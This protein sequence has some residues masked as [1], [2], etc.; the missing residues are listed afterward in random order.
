MICTFKH[1]MNTVE[2]RYRYILEQIERQGTVSVIDLAEALDVSDMTIRRDL[3][4]L[5][6]IGMIRRVHGGAVSARGRSF[7]PPLFFRSTENK[8]VKQLLGKYAAQMISE[9]D[10]ITLDV[11]STAYE[12]AVNLADRHN[13]TL[14]TPS[15]P[16]ANLFLNR[17]DVRLIIPGGIVRP[18]ESSMVGELAR[19]N[20][21]T[22]FVDRLFLGMAAI[23]SQAGLTEYNM[24]DADVKKAMIKNAKEVVLVVD[25]SKFEKTAFAFVA[26]IK[27][28]HHLI[29][30]A[31]PPKALLSVLKANSVAVH[32]VNEVQARLQREADDTAL[33]TA[34]EPG[35]QE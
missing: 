27:A 21:E 14:I 4:E 34:I 13:I 23:D 18:G 24:D 11:G 6:R 12:I 5:E 29:T 28:V 7:E 30:D 31:E 8:A 26:P 2:Y 22:L 16:I 17:S 33:D 19:R 1:K 35:G 20:L 32:I 10:S 15:I 9:G 25:S 3:T